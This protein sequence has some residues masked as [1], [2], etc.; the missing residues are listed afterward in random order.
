MVDVILPEEVEELARADGV[1]LLGRPRRRQIDGSG[2]AWTSQ[3][4][5][6]AAGQLLVI[7]VPILLIDPEEIVEELDVVG[8]C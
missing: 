2:L 1:G 8:Q 5:T 7:C 3:P 6:L 4:V